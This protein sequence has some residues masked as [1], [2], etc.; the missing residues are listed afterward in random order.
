MSEAELKLFMKIERMINTLGTYNDYFIELV[1]TKVA[2]R[3][4]FK[5]SYKKHELFVTNDPKEIAKSKKDTDTKTVWNIDHYVNN[6]YSFDKE[7]FHV[8][9]VVYSCWPLINL[10]DDSFRTET[11]YVYIPPI[12]GDK[13]QTL[14]LN[15]KSFKLKEQ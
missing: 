12:E 9:R 10:F 4:E 7:K 11:I 5:K 3:I 14:K 1:H 13:I 6:P 15:L 8:Y 2:G